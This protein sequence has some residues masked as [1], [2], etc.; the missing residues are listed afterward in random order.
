M[1]TKI[2]VMPPQADRLRL[3]PQIAREIELSARQERRRA[4]QLA[5]ELERQEALR[6]TEL[7][8]AEERASQLGQCVRREQR[9]EPR[10]RAAGMS[11]VAA[12][13]QNQLHVTL[14]VLPELLEHYPDFVARMEGLLARRVARQVKVFLSHVSVVDDGYDESPI[15]ADES[16]RRII[17]ASRLH[18][19]EQA[20]ACTHAYLQM[21][22][23]STEV[24]G[25][26]A[27]VD[28]TIVVF[29]NRDGF[30]HCHWWRASSAA[31]VSA[32]KVFKA[33]AFTTRTIS[34]SQERK[35]NAVARAIGNC[36]RQVCTPPE[37]WAE[38]AEP[39]RA[40]HP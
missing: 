6:A 23:V 10:S 13:P 14:S 16:I 40:S 3:N 21:L 25:G 27:Q 8:L 2:F 34:V 19:A 12:I 17:A 37:G 20:R 35:L 36:F 4:R 9:K 15:T 32:D 30:L 22:R 31:I 29:T 11:G 1:A 18:F 33:D 7:R 5:A 26:T 38:E 24:V 28:G 39:A